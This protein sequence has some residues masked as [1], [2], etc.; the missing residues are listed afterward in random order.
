MMGW[1]E[2]VAAIIW[3]NLKAAP[4]SAA[5]KGQ[6]VAEAIEAFDAPPAPE[7]K[8]P[9]AP[10][11]VRGESLD[12]LRRRARE[13]GDWEPWKSSAKTQKA[14]SKVFRE[15]SKPGLPTVASL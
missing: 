15:A 9:D 4:I 13:W 2:K 10:L 8:K 12:A 1:K 3:G 6:I 5:M 11:T 14:K 7:E